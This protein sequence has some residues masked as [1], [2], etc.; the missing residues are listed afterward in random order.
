VGQGQQQ[1]CHHHTSAPTRCRG[2]FGGELELRRPIN[3]TCV[4]K[5]YEKISLKQCSMACELLYALES[6]DLFCTLTC[7]FGSPG[8]R[9]SFLELTPVSSNKHS[10]LTSSIV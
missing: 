6:S 5:S 8:A 3:S 4:G 1:R 7:M 10:S 2:P 9:K